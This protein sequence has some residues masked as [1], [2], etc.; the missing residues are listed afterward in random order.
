MVRLGM[1]CSSAYI[2]PSCATEAFVLRHASKH[3]CLLSERAVEHLTSRTREEARKFS[4]GSISLLK[5]SKHELFSTLCAGNAGNAFLI[6]TLFVGSDIVQSTM[7]SSVWSRCT[8]GGVSVFSLCPRREESAR[9]ELISCQ[10]LKVRGHMEAKQRH[11]L[12]LYRH[13]HPT[14]RG[15]SIAA[16]LKNARQQRCQVRSCFQLSTISSDAA[17]NGQAQVAAMSASELFM[18]TYAI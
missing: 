17:F 10:Q 11:C 13:W 1:C 16:N 7:M 3:R 9:L 8:G 15:P 5:P 6:R 14:G 4:K 18:I 2:M 12:T